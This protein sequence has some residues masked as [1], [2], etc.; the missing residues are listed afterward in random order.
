M[1]NLIRILPDS[2][3]NQIAAGEVIQRPS[4]VVKELVENSIDAKATEITINI[5]DAGRTLIQ[6]IDNGNGMNHDDARLCFE[7]H[8]TSKIKTSEDLFH[9]NT[10]GFRGE[11][12]ASIAA[13]A[14]VELKTR[15]SDSQTGT[16]IEIEATKLKKIE[17][18]SCPQGS[19]FAVKNLFF[20]LPARRKFLKSDRTE[21]ANILSE[22]YRLA[23]AHPNITFTL[24][25][26]ER[27]VKKL[28]AETLKERINNAFDKTLS[29]QLIKLDTDG[30]FVKISGF[31]GNP[32]FSVKN[33]PKQ[34]F[35]VN[36]RFMKNFY[37]HKAVMLGYDQLLQADTKP[38]Y[39]IFFEIN[40]D[41][42]DV[43]IHPTKTE[44][45]FENSNAIFQILQAAVRKALTEFDIPPAI[46]FDNPELFLNNFDKPDLD[47]K[48]P[49][50]RLNP[51]YNPF[52]QIQK[53]IEFHSKIDKNKNKKEIDPFS[54]DI[55]SKAFSDFEEQKNIVVEPKF[56]QYKNKYIITTIKSGLMLVN[57]NRAMWQ[58][59]FEEILTKLQ[60]N[61][62]SIS[63]I[64]PVNVAFSS[65]EILFFDEI[66][67]KL[68]ECGFRFEK[69]NNLL[70][71]IVGIPPFVEL[72]KAP[73]IVKDL[74]KL[75]QV[76]D[77]E[78]N[79]L[80]YSDIA[81]DIL[82]T[83]QQNF[84][85]KNLSEKNMKEIVDKLLSSKSPQYTFDGKAIIT[86]IPEE[87]INDMFKE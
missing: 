61:A 78:L 83:N 51:D 41:Q 19:N 7:R 86:I 22:F 77:N 21:F 23:I 82:R 20:N 43:N 15:T 5:K 33:N 24:I 46:D 32:A 31:I 4:S 14:T 79:A 73:K 63:T 62:S 27:I 67:E 47:V 80:D 69:I 49:Q 25:H 76:T 56:I 11:A 57:I 6:V 70:Y 30:G 50:I 37:F 44:I 36:G 74:V 17:Q 34:F 55:Y 2:L 59:K 10:K 58:I 53:E 66:K 26:N 1:S 12:L 16:F 29:K 64:H 68:N 13:V 38:N 60:N 9:I 84:I 85:P 18:I 72:S 71:N 87:Q 35:F 42:I 39:F 40:P 52:E 48:A 3:A 54:E 45:N 65:D 28:I 81:E 75:A 8:A